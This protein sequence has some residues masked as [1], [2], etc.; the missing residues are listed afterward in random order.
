MLLI[1]LFI[2]VLALACPTVEAQTIAGEARDFS[3]ADVRRGS[4]L[5]ERAWWDVK[6]YHLAVEVFPEAKRLVG[7]NRITFETTNAGQQMQIDLQ[8]PLAI[9]RVTHG[10]DELTFTRQGNYYLIDFP[11]V[12]NAGIETQIEVFYEGQPKEAKNPPWDGGIA[13]TKDTEDRPFIASACQGIGASIWWPCKDHGADEPDRG[14]MISLTVPDSLTGVANGRLVRT[15]SNKAKSTKTFHWQVTH[16]IN[17][18]CVNMNVGRYVSFSEQYQGAFGTLD[19]QHWVLDHQRDRAMQHFKEAPRVMAAFEH[20]FGKYPFYR[21]SYKLVVAPY[22]GMEHQSSV[23]YG[24]GFA[25]GYRGRDLSD[26]GVGLLFDFIIVHESGHE[27]FGNNV[28]MKDTADMWIHESF[29]NYAENLF[30]EY[31]FG[32]EKAQDYVIGTRKLIK[33][34][35]PIVG[36]SGVNHEGSGDMYYKGGNMLHTLRHIVN[37]REKWRRILT[38]INTDFQYQTVTSKQVENY[39][40]MHTGIELSKFFD[41]YLRTIEVPRFVFQV[42]GNQLIYQYE[43]VVAGFNYPLAI[44]VNGK[45]YRIF[46]QQNQQMV[47]F[48]MPI[49]SC[50]VDRNFYVDS[51]QE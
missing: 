47:R 50:E 9:T 39:M 10:S 45:S 49:D 11:Q 30:V 37:D 43:N 18:Y 42:Q 23:T 41:Q 21:D 7:S 3:P 4:I 31:H 51:V 15:E 44:K 6:H 12:L 2:I 8:T 17:S 1:G 35:R 36:V 19:M 46:P 16:P 38:G 27:W 24:N 22:L 25:N 20:W 33:N 40:S 29:T 28:S 32:K 13:W 14:V 34:D 48:A 26:T 5:P